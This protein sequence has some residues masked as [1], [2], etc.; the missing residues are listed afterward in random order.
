MTAVPNLHDLTAADQTPPALF[1]RTEADLTVF[2]DRAKPIIEAVRREGDAALRRF[3]H[4]FDHAPADLS[5]RVTEA[6]FDAAAKAVSAEVRAALEFAIDNIRRFHEAQKPEDMWLKEIQPG[7]FAGDRFLPIESIACYV[8]RGKGSFPSVFMMTTIP[9]KVAGVPRLIVLTPPGPDGTVDAAT[10]VAARLIGVTE[11]YKC[12]G[13]QGVSAVAFGTE[14][15]PKCLKIVGPGSPWV[16]AAKRLLSDHID[17]GTPAGPSEAIVLADGAANGALAALDLII[18]SEHGPDSSAYLVTS[19]RRVAEEARAALPKYW[20][21]MEEGRAK[22]SQAVLCGPHGGIVLTKDFDAAIAFVNDYAPEH[23]EI[24]A[25]EP[26]A[27][28]GRIKNAGEILLGEYTPMTIG[29]FVLGPNA[30]LPTGAAAK[31]ASPLSVFDYMKRSSIGYVTKTG[32]PPLAKHAEVLARYE[33][34]DGHARAVSSLRA[35]IQAG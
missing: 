9:G 21:E 34:F 31:T 3:A 15:V 28:M 1:A 24:L 19:S 13:A 23:L 29:N 35:K 17:P 18:E 32:F 27:V 7:V 10:L 6:E 22:F 12:G 8:P 30:V 5:L 26:L 20:A 14:T 4:E 11:V 2:M 25:A 16:V 33:G